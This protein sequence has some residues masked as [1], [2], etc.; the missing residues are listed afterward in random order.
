MFK[1]ILVV[2]VVISL[3]STVLLVL[4]AW[5]RPQLDSYAFC[6]SVSNSS[7]MP[8]RKATTFHTTD[9]EVYSWMRFNNVHGS[10]TVQWLWI[11]PQK[12]DW[13]VKEELIPAGDWDWYAVWDSMYLSGSEPFLTGRWRVFVYLDHKF[14]FEH[15]FN[16]VA[17]WLNELE[18]NNSSARADRVQVSEQIHAS[19][20]RDDP[21]WFRVQ[22]DRSG[23]YYVSIA[24]WWSYTQSM[25]S[26]FRATDL[27]NPL[28]LLDEW[29]DEDSD[30]WLF[31][32]CVLLTRP[33]TYYIEVKGQYSTTEKEYFLRVE[34][35]MPWWVN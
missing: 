31:G 19:T 10:H 20:T 18:P 21:D 14:L 23:Q 6:H 11:N 13:L 24:T 2:S 16:L 32:E 28:P 12:S 30:A 5:A 22:I 8:I 1:R 9:R 26:V 4:P 29:E 33:G 35:D 25:L 3:F 15:D 34:E 7:Y 27:Q 17:G